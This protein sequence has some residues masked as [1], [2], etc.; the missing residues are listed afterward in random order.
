MK[1][2]K[3]AKI[4]TLAF[5]RVFFTLKMELNELY[6]ISPIAC[7]PPIFPVFSLFFLV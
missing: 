7:K 5:M 4:K 2:L 3:S 6:I 1:T